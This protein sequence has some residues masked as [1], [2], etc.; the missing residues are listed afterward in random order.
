MFFCQLSPALSEAHSPPCRNS[1]PNSFGCTQ[2][3]CVCNA[4]AAL[5]ACA[6]PQVHAPSLCGAVA[7]EILYGPNAPGEICLWYHFGSTVIPGPDWETVAFMSDGAGSWEVGMG[8]TVVP[9]DK[10]LRMQR[11]S[12]TLFSFLL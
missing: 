12:L 7:Q 11:A 3:C 4:S 10:D 1:R 2:S 8:V 6:V 5:V 9:S